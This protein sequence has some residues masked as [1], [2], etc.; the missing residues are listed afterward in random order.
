MKEFRLRDP[1]DQPAAIGRVGVL[2]GFII[3]MSFNAVDEVKQPAAVHA[4]VGH[5]F[6]EA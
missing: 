3:V 4:T 6:P 2:E 1:G 5:F